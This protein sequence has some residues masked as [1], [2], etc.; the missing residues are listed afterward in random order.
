LDPLIKSRLLIA[1][2]TWR[3]RVTQYWDE[4]SSRHRTAGTIERGGTAVDLFS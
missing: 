4:I 3:Q 2:R 1:R